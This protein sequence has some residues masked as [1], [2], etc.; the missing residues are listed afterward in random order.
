MHL[1]RDVRSLIRRRFR[2]VRIDLTGT[3]AESLADAAPDDDEPADLRSDSAIEPK[4]ARARSSVAEVARNQEEVMSLVRKIGD[5]LDAQTGRTQRLLHLMERMPQALD[6]LPEINRQNSRLL[7][8]LHDHFEQSRRREEMLNSTLTTIGEASGR[9]T[10]VL[11]L[12]QQQLDTNSQASLTMTETLGDLRRSLS[13]LAQ[14]NTQTSDVL[15]KIAEDTDR[16]E[17]T[18][19]EALGRTQQWMIIAVACCAVAS[20]AAIVAAIVAAV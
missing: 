7:D 20:L 10:E 1:L 4:P 13:E 15:A 12:V 2:P 18:L 14:S 16:R 5:H 9:Q 11:S 17:T 3:Q 19:S 8:S 6:A